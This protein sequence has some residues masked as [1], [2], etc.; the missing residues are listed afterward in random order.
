MKKSKN[1]Q[2]KL[3][4]YLGDPVHNLI[5]S[6]DI[7]TIPLNICNISSYSKSFFGDQIEI[8]LFKFPDLMLKAIDKFQPD[9]VG[10]SNYL[11]NF[12]LSKKI[13]EIV[14]EKYPKAVTVM[15][16][17][18]IT[19]TKE[20]MTEFFNQSKVDF[21]IS[22]HAEEPFKCIVGAMLKENYRFENLHKDKDIHGVW[23][24]DPKTK[25][26]CEIPAKRLIINLDE[27]PSPFLNGI[28]DEFFQQDLIPMIETNRGCPFQCTYCDWGSAALRKMTKYSIE[29]VKKDI[30][31]CSK[32]AKDE[33]LMID[34]ANFG[35]LGERDLKIAQYIKDLRDRERYPGKLIVTWSEAKTD[36]I[37]KIADTLK[38]LLMITT[39]FQ[40]MNEEVLR[41]IKRKNINDEQFKKIIKFSK[42]RK[43]DTYGE[44]MVALPGETLKSHFDALR[45]LFDSG[46]DFININPLMLLQGS[47]LATKEERE[48]YGLKT[49]WR[50]LENC[51]GIYEGLSII[52]YQEMVIQ[53]NTM[54]EKDV[55]LCRPV[56]WLIQMSWNLRRHDIL[57]KYIQLLGINPMDFFLRLIKN[58]KNADPKVTAIFES[59]F[60]DAK[61]E[62]FK[63]KEEL[64]DYY[65]QPEQLEILKKGGFRKMNTHYTSRVS[66]ECEKE[67]LDYC[68]ATAIEII[69]E[70]NLDVVEHKKMIDECSKFIFNRYLHFDDFKHI[71]KGEDLKKKIIF[72]YDFLEWSD[73]N[74]KKPLQ[75]YYQPNGITIVFSIG[76]EQKKAIQEHLKRFSGLSDE[77]RLRK[78]QEP[79]HGIHK[80][81]LLFRINKNP[82]LNK[83]R[84]CS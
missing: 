66:L 83:I 71:E 1:T 54:S 12:E 43:I 14:K 63:T 72:Y 29:R 49:K 76:S 60:K 41:N 79:Y 36:T 37:L 44:L 24:L 75:S 9:I 78:L 68:K 65:S 33:R 58:Y 61:E 7:W 57:I 34:D 67:F 3:V 30:E 69:K 2:K 50:L 42:K 55:L 31:Y 77:Y 64:I 73:D 35:I 5:N 13:I 82:V 22:F 15:G 17:P 74:Y 6:R 56:S 19:Q 40:S 81:H 11:W 8:H 21:Y 59:F 16:G 18:N 51:Y 39:S 32:N 23:F 10:L 53:T 26:A 70:K 27:I 38:D 4:I 45:Y 48:K 46:V 80:K 47:K 52:E 28:A 25:Q 84:L 20:K 62:L